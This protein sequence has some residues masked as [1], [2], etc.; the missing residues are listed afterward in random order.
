MNT[1]FCTA[2]KFDSIKS[3]WIVGGG[4][5]WMLAPRWSLRAEYLHYVF[6]AGRTN[7][8][9]FISGPV[10]GG[11]GP[12][13]LMIAPSLQ[14][15]DVA[16]LALNYHFANAGGEHAF[17]AAGSMNR[18]VAALPWSGF[19]AGVNAGWGW[20]STKGTATPAGAVAGPLFIDGAIPP[21][22][23]HE[24]GGLLGVNL[25]YNWQNG[26]WL[27]GI[28]G[29]LNAAS[30]TGNGQSLFLEG[31]GILESGLHV[32]NRVKWLATLRGRIG[33]S[34]R[35]GLLYTT[36]GAAWEQR[37]LKVS[38]FSGSTGEAALADYNFAKLGW[39]VGGGY[40]QTLAEH[41]SVRAEYLHYAFGSGPTQSTAYVNTAGLAGTLTI[42]P[43]RQDIDVVR[44]GL[45][46]HFT[47]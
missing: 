36:G 30:I 23:A 4:Y 6:G 35:A 22:S 17:A 27:L 26:P 46:R 10:F 39:V 5:E 42:A 44:V 16:R 45:N 33:T 12:T 37:T 18:A 41:W 14:N 34:I 43:S 29:D 11:G 25:G 40:E 1:G 28:E 19:Y 47:Q 7:T 20:S 24:N 31:G 13:T 21:F 8:S 15:V 9:S 3:G 32:E 2:S 38:Q